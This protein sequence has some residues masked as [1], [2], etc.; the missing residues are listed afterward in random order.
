MIFKHQVNRV[1]QFHFVF[2][3]EIFWRCTEMHRK[4]QRKIQI[5]ACVYFTHSI[6][7][8][9]ADLISIHPSHFYSFFSFPFIPID[10]HCREC[11]VRVHLRLFVDASVFCVSFSFL[12]ISFHF[13]WLIHSNF[14]AMHT[15]A[16]YLALHVGCVFL[17]TTN[18]I[19]QK[20]KTHTHTECVLLC[21]CFFSFLT[22]A[23]CDCVFRFFF[24][25]PS[26]LLN[27]VWR[28]C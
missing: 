23:K 11:S 9:V 10:S 16:Q 6:R 3:G 2:I 13:L 4:R 24:F 8:F 15:I 12:F 17:C 14:N 1:H 20:R 5:N 18:G 27:C 21:V 19:A 26:I 22:L 28:R 7:L 25:Y